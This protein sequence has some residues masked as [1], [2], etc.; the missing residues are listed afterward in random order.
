MPFRKDFSYFKYKRF[1][2]IL[3]MILIFNFILIKEN[4]LV[5][6]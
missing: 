6:I 1:K 2:Y 5:P 3:I 4:Y